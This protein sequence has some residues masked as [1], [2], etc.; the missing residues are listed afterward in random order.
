VINLTLGLI[1]LARDEGY[2]ICTLNDLP[3][4]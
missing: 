1:Q 3:A 4:N 2:D